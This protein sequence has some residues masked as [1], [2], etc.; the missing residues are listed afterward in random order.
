MSTYQ[1][2]R[3]AIQKDLFGTWA[4]TP[5]YFENDKPK[6]KPHIKEFIK[7]FIIAPQSEQESLST[8]NSIEYGA[9]MV[10]IFT[11]KNI[12]ANRSETIKDALRLL[13]TNK[14]ED[15]ERLYINNVVCSRV[16]DGD[17]YYQENLEAKF[18]FN[19]DVNQA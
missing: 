17:V 6:T 16:P 1:T 13:L 12:G 15:N 4:M 8:S 19:Y 18:I 14:E 10:Q 3:K 11:K 7:V 5:V 9:I 2:R